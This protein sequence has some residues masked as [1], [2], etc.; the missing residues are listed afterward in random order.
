MKNAT[1]ERQNNFDLLRILSTFA[2][3][4]IHINAVI[5]SRY[6]LNFLAGFNIPTPINTVTRFCVPCFV[7]ISGAFILNNKENANFKKVL[8]KIL[9]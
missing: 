1:I 8:Q 3:V 4:L 9:L 2:V 6:H 5:S 7:M